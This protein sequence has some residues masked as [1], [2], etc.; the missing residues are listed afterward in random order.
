M[1]IYRVAL[2]KYAISR[3]FWQGELAIAQ[4]WLGVRSGA[5]VPSALG[6]YIQL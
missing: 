4:L 5:L 6:A 2:Y 3:G 1:Q